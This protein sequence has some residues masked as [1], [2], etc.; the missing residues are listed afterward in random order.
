MGL[1]EESVRPEECNP[2]FSIRTRVG[3]IQSGEYDNSGVLF[4]FENLWGEYTD[5]VTRVC[6]LKE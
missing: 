1:F 3:V 2:T 4:S 6:L 5:I